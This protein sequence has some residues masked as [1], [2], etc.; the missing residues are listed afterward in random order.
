MKKYAVLLGV[1]A[2]KPV[3]LDG[4]TEDTDKMVD[5]IEKLTLDGGKT[6]IGGKSVTVE[7]AV[8]LHT[9]K[10]VIKKRNNLS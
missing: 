9:S 2:G 6:K 3:V 5:A 10:G 1:V 7:D 8:I 4:P